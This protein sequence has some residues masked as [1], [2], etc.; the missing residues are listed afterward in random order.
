MACLV[1]WFFGLGADS[2][3]G[4]VKISNFQ[5]KKRVSF[6]RVLSNLGNAFTNPF[7]GVK[8]LRDKYA[9]FFV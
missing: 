7:V 4:G 6:F 5:G 2:V 8:F 1:C 9:N 3:E